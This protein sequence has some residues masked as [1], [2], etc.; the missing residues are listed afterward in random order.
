MTIDKLAKPVSGKHGENLRQLLLQNRSRHQRTLPPLQH[1]ALQTLMSWQTDRLRTTHQDLFKSERY[2]Q[3][4]HYFVDDLYLSPTALQRDKDLERV[5][6]TMIKLLPDETL[7][8]VANAVELNILSAE[9]DLQLANHLFD[10]TAASPSELQAIQTLPDITEFNYLQAYQLT[11][12]ATLR[13]QQLKLIEIIG[14]DLDRLVRFPLISM[15]LKLI[16][17]PAHKKGLGNLHDFLER[18][19]STFKALGGAEEFMGII[20]FREGQVMRNLNQGIP[21]PFDITY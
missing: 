20:V 12:S 19:F 15:T 2:H 7:E 9:L 14:H 16:R 21:N 4:A 6:P 10:L 17:R 8:T 11:D 5:F 18:G 3:A 1:H 13:E